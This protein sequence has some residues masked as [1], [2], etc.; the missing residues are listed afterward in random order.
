MKEKHN[1]IS[2]KKI[3]KNLLLGG[4]FFLLIKGLIWLVIFF[5]AALGF[6]DLMN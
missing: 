5:A 3:S 4:S 1:N 6:T 2:L